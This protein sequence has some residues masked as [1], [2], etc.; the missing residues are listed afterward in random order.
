MCKRCSWVE[1]KDVSVLAKLVPQGLASLVG[2][3]D[4]QL[5]RCCV[6]GDTRKGLAIFYFWGVDSIFPE[7]YVYLKRQLP[8]KSIASTT[9]REGTEIY[10]PV[11]AGCSGAV[12]SLYKRDEGCYDWPSRSRMKVNGEV[13]YGYAI[14]DCEICH[15]DVFFVDSY[16][17]SL[18][19][20]NV[21]HF[22]W[23]YARVKA[24]RA[25]KVATVKQRECNHCGQSYEPARLT[26]KF[27]ST[28]CR[29]YAS[30]SQLPPVQ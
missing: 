19:H 1:I 25:A 18:P 14:P 23:R 3:L 4:E 7:E 6:C 29:V 15:K 21:C 2:T 24:R 28:K 10:I 16:E 30:R 26:S 9:G 13:F 27:C 17:R 22:C 20:G 5:D 12:R 11:C 8:V